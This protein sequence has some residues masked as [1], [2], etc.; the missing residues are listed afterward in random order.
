M[1]VVKCL[2]LVT[3]RAYIQPVFEAI[4]LSSPRKRGSFLFPRKYFEIAKKRLDKGEEWV[5]SRRMDNNNSEVRKLRTQLMLDQQEFA[6]VMA[7][8]KGTVSRWERGKQKPRAVHLR[9]MARL[10][11]KVN[12]AKN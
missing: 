11:K 12:N 10:S 4:S 8:D 2:L 5:Y 7:V 3:T 9:R 6:D 1:N